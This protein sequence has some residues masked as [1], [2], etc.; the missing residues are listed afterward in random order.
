MMN[1]SYCPK[2]P[3]C[4]RKKELEEQLEIARLEREERESEE[5]L[6]EEKRQKRTAAKKLEA[7][8]VIHGNNYNAYTIADI[9]NIQNYDFLEEMSAN[10]YPAAQPWD[11][12]E[13]DYLNERAKAVHEQMFEVLLNEME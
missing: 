11:E 12:C 2:C 3:H 9:R 4:Q 6:A 10:V 13:M 7:Q 1:A 8:G 5:R